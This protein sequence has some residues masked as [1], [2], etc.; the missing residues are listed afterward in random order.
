MKVGFIGT[1]NMG[2]AIIRAYSSSAGSDTKI[3]AYNRTRAKAEALAEACGITIASDIEEITK[4]SD[5]L[6]VCVE[7]RNF[8]EVMPE[9][10][11]NFTK[12]KILVSIAAG[13]TLEDLESYLGSDAKIIRTMPNTPIQHGLGVT[14]MVRNS[15]VTD[16]DFNAVSAV[17]ESGGITGEISE[18]L[19]SAVV[20]ISGSSPAYTYIYI[21]AL[22]KAGIESGLDPDMSRLF[23]SQA[24]M[25]AARMVLASDESPSVLCDRVCTPGGITIEAVA[26]LRDDDFEN[27][28]KKGA[29]TAVNK[30][31]AMTKK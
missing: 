21:D 15:N 8:A 7:P 26:S 27:I 22:I 30:S 25:G 17:F 23:A 16:E 19:I 13:I 9:I 14:A 5:I 6:F 2:S 29:L 1:G 12:D 20:G 28:A 24:V 4:A 10:S 3:F 18:D 11:S 31:I